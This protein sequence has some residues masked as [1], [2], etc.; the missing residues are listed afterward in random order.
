MADNLMDIKETAEYLKMNKMTIYKLAREGRM[1]AFR[2][3]SEWRF[4]KDLID[5]WLI[6]QLKGKPVEGS[7]DI[8]EPTGPKTILIV[9]DEQ[10]ILDFFAG[11][12]KEYRLL[13]AKSG[14]E[15]LEIIKTDKPNLV[16]L[17]LKM[18][19]MDGIE[20]LRHIKK[21]DK[22]I[23]VIMM[24][25]YGTP[26]VQKQALESGAHSLMA[27]PFEVPE[28]KSVIIDSLRGE[29]EKKDRGRKSLSKTSHPV[30]S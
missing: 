4:R 2:V 6:S 27:K 21:L 15:A 19:G 13:T 30:R 29:R 10:V 18:P 28:I 5:R 14:E 22:S 1:P 9:D 25:A 3:A 26:E 12:L 24:T 20:T 23:G 8:T 7:M 11:T 17:D 16:L